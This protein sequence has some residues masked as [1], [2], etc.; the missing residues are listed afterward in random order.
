M[1]EP[2]YNACPRESE[3]SYWGGGRTGRPSTTR[4]YLRL[5]CLQGN[6][7]PREEGGDIGLFITLVPKVLK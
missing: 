5:L 1:S 7:P 6:K 4:H 3:H 2:V